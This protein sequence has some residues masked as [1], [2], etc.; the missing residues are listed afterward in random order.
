MEKSIPNAPTGKVELPARRG[1]A[2][3]V[4]T[5]VLLFGVSFGY[6]EAAVVVYL[7]ALYEPL[8]QRFHPYHAAGELFPLLRL[9]QLED[10]RPQAMRWLG[11]ELVREAATLAML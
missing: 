2:A 7:R 10:A 4:L 9:D 6:V 1:S 11:M 5:A 8:Q 3:R